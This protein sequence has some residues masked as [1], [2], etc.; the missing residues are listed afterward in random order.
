MFWWYT[1]PKWIPYTETFGMP[2]VAW[3]HET[4]GMAMSA[5]LNKIEKGVNFNSNNTGEIK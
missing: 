4:Y 5:I 1:Q 2:G 3:V